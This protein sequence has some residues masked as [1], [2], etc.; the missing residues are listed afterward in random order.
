MNND[1]L[2]EFDTTESTPSASWKVFTYTLEMV[3]ELIKES[4]YKLTTKMKQQIITLI[5][6]Q[7]EV[8]RGAD[9]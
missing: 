3:V 6:Q 7:L 8:L 1:K 2:N 5:K 4:D 9:I